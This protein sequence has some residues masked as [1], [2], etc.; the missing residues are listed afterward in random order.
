MQPDRFIQ[1]ELLSDAAFGAGTD[2]AGVVDV[3]AEHD[4]LGL[5]FLGGKTLRGLLRDSW[6]SME[7]F[8]PGLSGSPERV[9][10]PAGD[11]G[12]R[13]ILRLGDAVVDE[14]ARKWV[15]AAQTRSSHPVSPALVLEALTVI[16]RQTAEERTTGAPAGTTLRAVRLVR[17][18]LLLRAPLYWLADPTPEDRRCLALALLATRHAGLGRHRGRGHIRLT[19]NGDPE[20]TRRAAGMEEGEP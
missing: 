5:P 15:A 8:F 6:L 14:T 16:R 19:L 2:A 11:L 4:K 7:R 12:E 18:G 9:F 10:G 20:E 3:E 13:S 1:V 17:R